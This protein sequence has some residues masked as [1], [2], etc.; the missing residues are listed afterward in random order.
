MADIFLKKHNKLFQSQPSTLHEICLINDDSEISTI[1]SSDMI[2]RYAKNCSSIF[3]KKLFH[4][5][6]IAEHICKHKYQTF[7]NKLPEVEKQLNSLFDVPRPSFAKRKH[8]Y[9]RVRCFCEVCVD[10][11]AS[12]M[13][14]CEFYGPGLTRKTKINVFPL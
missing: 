12:S 14:H 11:Q 4:K 13:L 8:F 10:S 5:V 3:Y 7:L 2:G 9:D 1:L 6:M